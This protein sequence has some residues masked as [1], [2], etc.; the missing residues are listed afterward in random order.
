MINL[1]LELGDSIHEKRGSQTLPIHAAAFM[2]RCNTI[3]HLVK[4]GCDI[5]ALSDAGWTPL[6][7][8][9][10]GNAAAAI[11]LLLDLGALIQTSPSLGASGSAL[12]WVKSSAI[13]KLLIDRGASVHAQDSEGETPLCYLS[14]RNPCKEAVLA[15]LERGARVGHIASVSKTTPIILAVEYNQTD[16]RTRSNLTM[17]LFSLP[18]TG[19]YLVPFFFETDFEGS[20]GWVENQ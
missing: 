6:I 11:N 19:G 7:F 8:A 2:N 15:L 20:A 1:L 5:N 13:A 14:S 9:A 18:I 17:H 4:L 12:H 10:R 16:V 3:K